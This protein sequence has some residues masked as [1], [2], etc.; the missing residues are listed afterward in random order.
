MKSANGIGPRRRDL[1]ADRL[2][3][4]GSSR[5]P[6]GQEPKARPDERVAA[7]QHRDRRVD[8]AAVSARSQGSAIRSASRRSDAKRSSAVGQPASSA[9]RRWARRT[10]ESTTAASPSRARILPRASGPSRSR[11][12][13]RMEAG[14]RTSTAGPSVA[15][16]RREA[17]RSPR[18]STSAR[19][20]QAVERSRVAS[21]G[22]EVLP[23]TVSS[24]RRSA[25]TD[26]TACQTVRAA[27]SRLRLRGSA[28]PTSSRSAG[29]SR[30]N[31]RRR[32]RRRSATGSP[33]TSSSQRG[34]ALSDGRSGRSRRT[35]A[36]AT[37]TAS[38]E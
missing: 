35:A 24:A 16:A 3:G 11:S 14:G 21:V 34:R 31:A 9:P 6:P 7:Q 17:A 20:R 10:R 36:P 8:A 19:I 5:D 27:A 4:G 15:C 37:A 23:V 12:I 33:A 13:P 18:S 25:M 38:A 22:T 29:E 1:G 2:L 32:R 30:S 28:P 26:R